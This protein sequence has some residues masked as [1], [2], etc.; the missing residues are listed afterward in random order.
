MKKLTLAIDVDNTVSN[1]SQLWFKFTAEAL[2]EVG[3]EPNPKPNIF[4]SR[5]A[6]GLKKGTKLYKYILGKQTEGNVKNWKDFTQ[7]KDASKYLQKLKADGHKIIFISARVDFFFGPQENAAEEMTKKWL[8]YKQIPYDACYCNVEEKGKALLK[9]NADV[10]VD[11][12]LK[13]CE[14]A[15]KEGKQAIY[16]DDKENP[17]RQSGTNTNPKITTTN[18]WKQIYEAITQ[19]AKQ[20]NKEEEQVK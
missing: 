8:D 14:M 19:L 1:S 11:D 6:F 10:L 17:I 20:E 7:V 3:I 18:T 16:L 12:G 2:K 13:Y 9:Y 5:E 15:L 4:S